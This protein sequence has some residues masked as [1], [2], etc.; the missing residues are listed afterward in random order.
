MNLFSGGY[1]FNTIDNILPDVPPQKIIAM[2]EA[3]N[4][5]NETL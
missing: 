2:F 3:I 4:E 1:V 5:F